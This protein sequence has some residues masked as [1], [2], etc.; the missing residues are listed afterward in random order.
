MQHPQNSEVYTDGSKS[1]REKQVFIDSTRKESLDE[2]AFIHAAEMTAIKTA[3]W[4]RRL[5]MSNIHRLV[6]FYSLIK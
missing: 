1:E 4:Q 3:L 6:E 2:K 5:M